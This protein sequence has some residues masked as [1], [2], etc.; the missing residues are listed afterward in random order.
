MSPKKIRS[1]TRLMTKR[2]S[3]SLGARRNDTSRGVTIAVKISATAV[4]P[5]HG[6]IVT[7]V[8][9]SIRYLLALTDFM[10]LCSILTILLAL[11]RLPLSILYK[12]ALDLKLAKVSA[13]WREP[14][15]GVSGSENA[16]PTPSPGLL[17]ML[18]SAA[19]MP[20]P[21]LRSCIMPRSCMCLAVWIPM[22]VPFVV[23]APRP[24]PT[25]AAT[26]VMANE[27]GLRSGNAGQAYP[28]AVSTAFDVLFSR[29]RYCARLQ[30]W[31][32]L[33]IRAGRDQAPRGLS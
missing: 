2:R 29:V 9:G 5:S 30:T 26:V 20:P 7:D 4:I 19:T 14:L 27:A 31:R 25:V 32:M 22:T 12:L 28:S 8:R 17:P 23:C 6:A 16:G 24:E 21:T 1:I 10:W 13:R 3:T 33:A 18:F 15:V 11:G